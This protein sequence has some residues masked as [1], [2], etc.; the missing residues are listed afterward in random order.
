MS[1]IR[2]YLRAS[3]EVQDAERARA[4][5]ERFTSDRSLKVASWYVENESGAK[6]ERPELFRLIRDASRGDVLLVEQ[7]DRV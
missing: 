3:S 6:L 2:G 5:L 4:D 1:F 7:V